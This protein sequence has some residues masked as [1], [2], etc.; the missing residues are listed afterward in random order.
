MKNKIRSQLVP[1]SKSDHSDHN[2]CNQSVI[3][4]YKI[5]FLGEASVGKTSICA[6]Y[7]EKKF[8]LNQESTVGASFLT[9]LIVKDNESKSFDIWDTAG[10]ER[11]KS[12]A[13]MY[14]RGANCVL[15]VFDI[16]NMETYEKAKSWILNVKRNISTTNL[17]YILVGNKFDLNSDRKIEMDEV[18]HYI[19]ET[20][21]PN[22]HYIEVSAKTGYQIKELFDLIYYNIKDNIKTLEDA[23]STVS[24]VETEPKCC[25]IS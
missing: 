20:C 6:S 2:Q 21:D 4:K 25:V 24:L 14:Y 13:P 17:L 22:I 19:K 3:K 11:Y 8:K 5:V 16:T 1:S 12:L 7:R 23:N 9:T 15:F 18:K 10:Q